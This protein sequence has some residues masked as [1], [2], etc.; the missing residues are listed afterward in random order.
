MLGREAWQIVREQTAELAIHVLDP[1]E[2][3]KLPS[4]QPTGLSRRLQ[5]VSACGCLQHW[6][7]LGPRSL[8]A[9]PSHTNGRETFV[10]PCPNVGELCLETEKLDVDF[11][12]EASSFA[13][14]EGF[15]VD[16]AN[17]GWHL[18]EKSTLSLERQER[19]SGATEREY[20]FTRL[21]AALIRLSTG[22]KGTFFQCEN[23]EEQVLVRLAAVARYKSL[24]DSMEFCDPETAG[25]S[26]L[27]H[28]PSHALIT[29]L[30]SVTL[31][32]VFLRST[33]TK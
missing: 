6:T 26:G 20:D 1:A 5:D 13:K 30:K 11:L 8:R 18:F 4:L 14:L 12:C 28:V 10:G 23:R 9:A 2:L 33:C 25:S 21:R 27:S 15:Q 3:R 24:D 22:S 32:I 29:E 7:S 17:M 16:L 19:V 31:G